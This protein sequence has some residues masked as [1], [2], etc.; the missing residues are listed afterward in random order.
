ME[1]SKILFWNVDSQVDFIEF[2]GKLYA[3]GAEEIKPRLKEIT[4]YARRNG[5]RVVNTCDYHNADS[6]EL[7]SNPDY[8]S[9]FPEHCMRGTTGAEYIPETKPDNPFII[10]WTAD[11]NIISKLKQENP[12]NIVIRKDVFDVFAG[13]PYTDQILQLIDPERIFVYG[14]TTNVCVDQAVMGL[15]KRGKQVTV[16]RDAI[17]E[18]PKI[19]L[20]FDKWRECGV[21][22]IEFSQEL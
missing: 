11:P 18:L 17:K 14:V 10:D 21:Q 15:T 8:I 4:E 9:S 13:N 12:R 6:K 19:P 22:M 20:P 16:F 2:T 7:S 1:K 3:P 5:I